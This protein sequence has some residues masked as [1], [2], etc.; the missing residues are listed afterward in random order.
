MTECI[1]VT[2]LPVREY[3]YLS[4][5]KSVFPGLECELLKTGNVPYLSP[6]GLHGAWHRDGI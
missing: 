3:N 4:I 5:Y 1:V 2:C 6:H